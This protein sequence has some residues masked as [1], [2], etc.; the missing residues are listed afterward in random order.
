M[1]NLYNDCS[2]GQGGSPDLL[3]GDQVA[4]ET[5]WGAL[6]ALER[7]II[8]DKRTVNVLG[9][10]DALKFRG[11]AFVWDEVVPDVETTAE[12]IDGIGTVSAS[13]IFFINSSTMEFIVDAETDWITTPFLRPVGQDA[14]VAEMLWMGALGI[15]NRRK[16][17]VLYG[18]SRSIAS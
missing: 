5:Y 3:V 10:A 15:N 11:A 14:R 9:G 4:W 16:N 18:I 13:T 8:E 1:N 17:G 6:A 2:K 7:Y 12:V